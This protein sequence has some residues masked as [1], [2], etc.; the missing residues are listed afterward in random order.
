MATPPQTPPPAAADPKQ[1][2]YDAL[3]AL[4]ATAAAAANNPANSQAAQDTAFALRTATQKQLDAL[5]LAVFTGNTVDLQAAA[6]K[7]T[8]GMT[9]LK[10]L[11]T[12]ITELGNDLKESASILGWIDKALTELTVLL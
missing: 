3:N 11:Q 8:P 10:A 12:K 4:L 6:A 5:D 9:D 1:A 2:A 7:L